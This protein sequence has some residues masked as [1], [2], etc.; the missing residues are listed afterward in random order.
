MGFKR[1]LTSPIQRRKQELDDA[2][3]G[4]LK[5]RPVV[6]EVVIK[7]AEKKP[8][9]AKTKVTKKVKQTSLLSLL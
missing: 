4:K 1:D 7:P 2:L 3:A 6:S 5:R 9:K 8:T